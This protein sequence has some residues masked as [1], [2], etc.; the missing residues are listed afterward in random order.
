MRCKKAQRSLEAYLGGE[1][2]EKERARIERHVASCAECARAL[3]H[4]R[5]LR[6]TLGENMTPPLP[7]G[8][9][10]QVMARAREHAG[11]RRWSERIL[12]PFGWGPAMPV[13]LRAAAAAAVIV[14]LGIGMLIGRDMWRIE[15]PQEPRPAQV[16]EADPVRLYRIDYLAEAPEGSMAGAYVSLVST[17][18]GE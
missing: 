8:F 15:Q 18:Q 17:G 3:D 6:K 10:A 11:E 7:G 13:G 12:S 16:A 4:A 9:H 2:T 1:L 14:A 5:Q